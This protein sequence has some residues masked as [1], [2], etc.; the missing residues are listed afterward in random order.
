MN[1]TLTLGSFGISFVTLRGFLLA[2]GCETKSGIGTT[3]LGFST[4]NAI[5]V[6]KKFMRRLQ[7]YNLVVQ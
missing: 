5:D 1:K 7:T 3:A 6:K 2:E 4:T